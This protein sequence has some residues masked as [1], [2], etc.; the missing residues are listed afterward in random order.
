MA[1]TPEYLHMAK[2]EVPPRAGEIYTAAGEQEFSSV[3]PL[4]ANK[5]QQ[6]HR[7]TP[8]VAIR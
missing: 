6:V 4:P 1:N 3:W 8:L 7:M 5:V 2:R